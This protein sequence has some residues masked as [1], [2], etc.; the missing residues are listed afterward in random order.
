[1]KYVLKYELD[2]ENF[3]ESLLHAKGVQNIE[4]F[5]NPQENEQHDPFLLSNMDSACNC[6]IKHMEKRS[7]MFIMVDS[8]M[9]GYMSAAMMY[10]YIKELDSEIE[11]AWETHEGKQHGIIMDYIPADCGLVIVPDA[12][13]NDFAQHKLLK[14]RGVDVI[15]IDHHECEESKDAIVVNNQLNNY[16]NKSLSGGGVVYKFLQA[17]DSKLNRSLSENYVDMAAISIVG[18]MMDLRDLENRY[19]VKTGL[20]RITNLG[21]RQIVEQQAYSLKDTSNL[22]PVGIAFFVVPLVN[23]LVRVGTDEEKKLLFRSFV[24][25]HIL[26]PSTKRGDKGKFE[27]IATQAVRNCVN[28]RSRQNR[29]KEKA[30]GEIDLLIQKNELHRNQVIFVSVDNHKMFDSTLTGLI[31]MNVLSKYKKPTIVARLNE[32]GFW[33]GSARGAGTPELKDLKAFF[34]DSGFFEYAEG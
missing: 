26:V 18:D 14:E 25:G 19:I 20:S 12:G 2:K 22:T 6:L 24:E 33:R 5:L 16:P 10:N 1:M 9:D 21:L 4:R 17:M 30:V 3:V 11:I 15:I 29:A 28:A 8:D 7:K 23:A 34:M 13:S 27:T 32:D 31:A